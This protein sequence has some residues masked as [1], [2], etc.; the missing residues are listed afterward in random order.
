MVIYQF[1]ISDRY[2]TLGIWVCTSKT[3]VLQI[4]RGDWFYEM[5]D[6]H[7][8]FTRLLLPKCVVVLLSVVLIIN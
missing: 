7:V 2:S 8:M 1:P 6:L 4:S 3:S 5:S